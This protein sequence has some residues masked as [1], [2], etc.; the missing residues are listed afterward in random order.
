MGRKATGSI[1][2]EVIVFFFNLSNPSS[3]SM[4]LEFIQLLPEMSI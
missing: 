4:V 2:Y 1:P 3:R